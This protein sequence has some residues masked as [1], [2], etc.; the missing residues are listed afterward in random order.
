MEPPSPAF[1]SKKSQIIR[2][3]ECPDDEYSD[4]SPK[5]S[6]DAPIRDEIDLINSSPVM[7]TTSSCSGRVAVFL[8][9]RRG[10]RDQQVP[11]SNTDEPETDAGVIPSAATIHESKSKIGQVGG[12]GDGGKWLFVSHSPVDSLASSQG[13]SPPKWHELFKMDNQRTGLDGDAVLNSSSLPVGLTSFVHLKF[14]P[15][16]SISN[17]PRRLSFLSTTISTGH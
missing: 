2:Q 17:R 13:N 6:I 10:Q 16:V 11:S 14:E 12:K 8:E 3:L 15:F 1:L 7:V 9:G 4:L 5:G